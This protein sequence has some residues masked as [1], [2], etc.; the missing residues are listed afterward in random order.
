MT[1][2]WLEVG[3]NRSNDMTGYIAY[4]NYQEIT[5]YNA[6]L[7]IKQFIEDTLGHIGELA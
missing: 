6:I 3:Y 2:I 7:R 4:N 5:C 1:G